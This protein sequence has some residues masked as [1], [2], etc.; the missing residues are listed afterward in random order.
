M[1]KLQTIKQ[2]NALE[3]RLARVV[4]KTKNEWFW[5]GR[6]E[7]FAQHSVNMD[8]YTAKFELF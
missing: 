6:P 2:P 3:A 5:K 8:G 4:F 1:H 7:R